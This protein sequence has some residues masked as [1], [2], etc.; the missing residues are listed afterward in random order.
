[1]GREG[2]ALSAKSAP[3]AV[4]WQSTALVAEAG[5]SLQRQA[6]W[7]HPPTRCAE[8]RGDGPIKQGR[9]IAQ[10]VEP[11]SCLWF[12]ELQPVG[13][14]STALRSS[15]RLLPMRET[16]SLGRAGVDPTQ[17]GL[18]TPAPVRLVCAIPRT[19]ATAVSAKARWNSPLAVPLPTALLG[20]PS[21]GR[22]RGGLTRGGR[23]QHDY[24]GCGSSRGWLT[25][26]H[27]LA[28]SRRC[29][30]AW[31]RAVVHRYEE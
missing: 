19:M 10:P 14:W 25:E 1:M 21:Q 23:N 12:N 28:I 5:G 15:S 30:T 7:R 29:S 27:L 20:V 24:K 9:G 31:R 6:R 2:C 22:R 13:S 3:A 4:T 17:Y 11:P 16:S 18:R 8:G 26:L